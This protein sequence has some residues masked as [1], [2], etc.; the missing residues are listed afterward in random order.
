M[1]KIQCKHSEEMN[2]FTITKDGK[3]FEKKILF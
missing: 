1:K 3:S 2:P